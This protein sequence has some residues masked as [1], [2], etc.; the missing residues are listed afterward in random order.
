MKPR[1]LRAQLRSSSSTMTTS[2]A[3]RYAPCSKTTAASSNA[4]EAARPFKSACLLVDAYLPGMSGLELLENLHHDGHSLPA[5][6]ITGNADVPMTVQAMRAG[7][8]D[9]IEKPIGR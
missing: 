5:I 3:S 7:A 6:I 1:A 8:L 4:M 2:F 9:F